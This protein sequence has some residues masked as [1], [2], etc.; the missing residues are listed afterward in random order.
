[1]IPLLMAGCYMTLG[2]ALI[3]GGLHFY[4]IRILILFGM[5]RIFMRGE[6]FSIRLNP[7]DKVL[8]AWLMVSSLFFVLFDGTN[9]R[10]TERLGSIYN[11]LGIYLFIRAVVWDLEDIVLIVKMFGIIIIPLAVLFVVEYVTGKNPFSILGGIPILSEV[12]NG[13][14]RCQGPFLHSILAGTFGATA[15]PFFVGW[16]VYSKRNRL[17]A[18]GA[19]L[20]ST[21]I[22]MASSSSGPLL[23][24]FI[25]IIGLICWAY[26]SHI[27]S[28]QWGIVLLLLGLAAYMD[29]PAWY[30]ISR[31]SDL[32]G[33][34]G[35]YRSALIDASI[36][37]FDEWWLFGTGYTA[38]WMPTGL[39]IDPNVADMTNYYIAQG[40]NGGILA[41]ILFV[42]LIVKCFKT[43]GT[44]VRNESRYSL[45]ERFMIWSLGCT[46]LGHAVSFLSVSYFDQITIF[47]YLVIGMIAA[48][49]HLGAANQKD[50]KL[51]TVSHSDSHVTS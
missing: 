50:L 38:H 46:V 37:H 11:T 32:T 31:M 14:I 34:G 42:W 17:L 13:R 33:G 41:M 18:T 10:I 3:V 6:I 9:A 47:W 27:R 49:L 30:L 23:A 20:A 25:S 51:S 16:W 15:M 44:A 28:I 45:V 22:V 24:Y 40:V 12:R 29:A 7:I 2:H 19:I 1:M 36:R 26:K 39:A 4:L 43:T 35:W 8:L 5:F 48:L 21:I